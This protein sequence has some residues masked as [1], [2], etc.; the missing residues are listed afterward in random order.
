MPLY[1]ANAFIWIDDWTTEKGNFA[2][3]EAS[4][5]GFDFVEIP[6]M[7]PWDFEPDHINKL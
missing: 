1:G 5:V 4:K 3:A 6:L 7:R 2:I